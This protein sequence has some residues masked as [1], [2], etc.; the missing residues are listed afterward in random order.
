MK[1]QRKFV[2]SGA[3]TGHEKE[4]MVY[5]LEAERAVLERYPLAQVFNPMRLPKLPS[6]EAY[7]V[8]CRSRIEHWATDI[9]YIEN[10]LRKMSKGSLEEEG[11]A[12]ER[13]LVQHVYDG[14]AVEELV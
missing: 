12:K 10:E 9:V 4:A 7:M 3:I 1:E 6:W 2:L 5:F 13:L 14:I 8:I 11:L